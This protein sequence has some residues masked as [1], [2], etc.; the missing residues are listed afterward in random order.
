LIEIIGD[1]GPGGD[2]AED[3]VLL[4]R[5]VARSRVRL[6]PKPIKS[7]RPVSAS[8]PIADFGNIERFVGDGP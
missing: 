4:S 5:L 7:Y 3:N 8:A 2:E 6:G 1:H